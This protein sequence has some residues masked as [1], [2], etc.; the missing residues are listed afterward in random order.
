[1]GDFWD[2]RWQQTYQV[3]P[4]FLVFVPLLRNLQTM[5]IHLVS[6][7]P[8]NVLESPIAVSLHMCLSKH[9]IFLAPDSI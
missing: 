3:L 8:A 7:L 2:A 5:K 4:L 9:H 6:L 1:M